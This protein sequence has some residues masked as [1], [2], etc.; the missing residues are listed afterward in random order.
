MIK[1]KRSVRTLI[2]VLEGIISQIKMIDDNA[3]DNKMYLLNRLYYVR[4]SL[5]TGRSASR[6]IIYALNEVAQSLS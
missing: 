4:Y 3:I 1:Q 6:Y 2:Y 5:Q